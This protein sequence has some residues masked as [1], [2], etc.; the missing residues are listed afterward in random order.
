[1]SAILATVLALPKDIVEINQERWYLH[2]IK[3]SPKQNPK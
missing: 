1:M 2:F 3:D